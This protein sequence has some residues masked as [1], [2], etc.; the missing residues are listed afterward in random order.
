MTL[1]EFFAQ[2]PSVVIAFSGGIDSAFLLYEAKR[3][4]RNVSAIYI[5]TGFQ[6]AFELNDAREFCKLYNIS[7]KVVEYDIY[8]HAEILANPTDRCYYCKRVIFETLCREAG[9]FLHDAIL[10][11]TNADDDES[12]RPGMRAL[13]ELGVLSPLRMCGMTKSMIR[14]AAKNA[15]ISLWNKPSYACLA[16]RIPHGE[17]ITKEKIETTETVEK[18]LM[19]MGF[20]NI[21]VRRTGNTAKIQI[22]AADFPRFIE[23]RKSILAVLKNYYQSVTL[24]LRARDE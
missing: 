13:K 19:E 18:Y 24:D 2:Y 3:F 8:N 9:A 10:D 11:G 6:P 5:K 12:D 21:R 17:C 4:A 22:Q 14:E 15:G 1:I 16:T 20:G 23:H 7:L